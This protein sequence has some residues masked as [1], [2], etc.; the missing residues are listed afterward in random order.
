M[1]IAVASQGR[2]LDS[3]LEP[4][5]GQARYLVVFDTESGE[6]G[7]YDNRDYIEA[8]QSVGLR[9]A[10]DLVYLGVDAVA[11]VTIAPQAASVL[12]AGEVEV[13]TDA[14]GNVA[15]AIEEYLLRPMRRV[16]HK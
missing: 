15:D 14:W 1:R 5:F 13:F 9:A 8:T 7:S 3:E 2:R 10:L 12:E 4:R 11:T 16:G 6:F